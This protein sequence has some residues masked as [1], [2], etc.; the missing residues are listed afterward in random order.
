LLN[1]RKFARKVLMAPAFLFAIISFFDIMV[2]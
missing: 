2:A 1:M